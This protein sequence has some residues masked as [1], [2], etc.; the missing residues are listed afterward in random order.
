MA[1]YWTLWFTHRSWVASE[2]TRSYYDF[3]NAFPLADGIVTVLIILTSWSLWR[4]RPTAVLFGLL[5]AGGGLY[6]FGIDVLFDLEHGIWTKGAN[7]VIELG[8]NL[9]TL[10]AT[11]ALSRWI[12]TNRRSLD[13]A[14]TQ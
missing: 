13:P 5:A 6:L 11:L 8:I 9:V 14:P 4:G 7:G 12:W 10:V 2:T 3:E 1:T